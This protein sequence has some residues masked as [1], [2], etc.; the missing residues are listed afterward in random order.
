MTISG[1]ISTITFSVS[2]GPGNSRDYVVISPPGAPIVF[3]PGNWR[4]LN[5]ANSSG[6][7]PVP[8]LT[9]GTVTFST[10]DVG[11]YEARFAKNGSTAASDIISSMTFSVTPNSVV[12][13]VEK[14]PP[15][16]FAFDLSTSGDVSVTQGASVTVDIRTV[17]KSGTSQN[18]ALS[19]SGLPQGTSFGLSP[20]QGTPPFSSVLTINTGGAPTGKFNI[21]VTAQDKSA[22]FALTINE[23]IVVSGNF[24]FVSNGGDDSNPGT[25]DRPFKTLQRGVSV[26]RPENT[27]LIRGGEYDTVNGLSSGNTSLIPSGLSWDKPVIIKA[28]TGEKVTLRRFMPPGSQIDEIAYR[29]S[30]HM[31]TPDECTGRYGR[32]Y[33]NYPKDCWAGGGDF[34]E[35]SQYAGSAGQPAGYVLQ[36]FNE[37][38]NPVQ[39]IIIDGID[40]D[41]RGIV[42]TL[43]FSAAAKHIR[44]Q[45]L[46]IRNSLKSAVAQPG[47]TS[48]IETD[49]QFISVKIHHC[50]VPYDKNLINGVLARKS[51]F[52]VFRH[53]WYMHSGGNRLIN[54]ETYENAGTGLGPDGN[55]NIITGNYIHD[56]SAQG[57]YMSGGNN[58]LIEGN[59]FFNNAGCEIYH[60]NGGGH[61]IRKNTVI[62]GPVND[63]ASNGGILSYGVFLH[64][65]S[66]ASLYLDNI[67]D[68]FRYGFWN[69]SQ[70][71][72]A[73]TI[74]NNLIRSKPFVNY[75][76]YNPGWGKATVNQDNILNQDPML[77]SDFKP[78]VGSPV[79]GKASDGG[80]IGAR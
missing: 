8:G 13:G 20:T 24:L 77:D 6:N 53:A 67:I 61:T 5:N 7:K 4:Y 23:R 14:Q 49:L 62:A 45:N 39:F 34:Q 40:I 16:P 1:K 48:D 55:N 31:P 52:A 60:F 74:K 66:W 11:D 25:Q 44:F 50:G 75:E 72:R 32:G 79:I 17:L 65:A 12:M 58:W 36:F 2:D 68:G 70:D 26:L 54:S 63:T 29:D 18:V 80:N 15:Q 33:G 64:D 38:A 69:Q 9:S 46:E 10:P 30:W 35:Q 42:S 59:V 22:V 71:P 3:S 19:V 41:A 21:T 43:S 47:V 51:R 78:K 73:T 56:N 28:F 27:L 57:L 37:D 76:I